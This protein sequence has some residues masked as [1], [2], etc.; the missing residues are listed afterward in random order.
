MLTKIK[1]NLYNMNYK[2]LK[3]F[4]KKEELN[5]FK[6]SL[7][8]EIHSLHKDYY[9]RMNFNDFFNKM[10]TT[11]NRLMRALSYRFLN[12][13]KFIKLKNKINENIFINPLFYVFVINKNFFK[14]ELE[15]KALLDT[16]FH[17]DFPFSL[18]SNTYWVALDDVNE[19]TGTLCFP[20]TRRLI[21]KFLPYKNFKNRYN[22]DK[23]YKNASK[24]DPLVRKDAVKLSLKAGSAVLWGSD[25][26]HGASRAKKFGL[27]RISF[28]FRTISKKILYLS[29]AK[30]IRFVEEFN[31]NID[32]FNFLNL[33]YIGDYKYCERSMKNNRQLSKYKNYLNY[34][35]SNKYKNLIKSS[36]FL[37]WQEEYSFT[38]TN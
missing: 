9:S 27:R 16:Q 36:S 35:K 31:E 18:Y 34:L 22:L 37:R 1:L 25:I 26:C 32:T 5:F 19:D 13:N 17:Y 6:K 29:N 24:L 38:K 14:S 2:I 11:Q 3:D 33:L 7:Y 10:F 12:K 20:K 28:N 23:Y 30:T 4:L 21:T 15:K 8:T